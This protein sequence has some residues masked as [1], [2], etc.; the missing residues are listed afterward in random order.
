MILKYFFF[1]FFSQWG[2]FS[3]GICFKWSRRTLHYNKGS[4][5]EWKHCNPIWGTYPQKVTWHFAQ[6]IL[7]SQVLL[8]SMFVRHFVIAWQRSLFNFPCNYF[9]F[10]FPLVG[11]SWSFYHTDKEN[12][13]SQSPVFLPNLLLCPFIYTCT[14]NMSYKLESPHWQT[15]RWAPQCNE[16]LDCYFTTCSV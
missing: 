7:F 8:F 16:S 10:A 3:Y 2:R 14:D 13:A 9:D 6:G 4:K 15:R 12:F 11:V 5:C 1:F